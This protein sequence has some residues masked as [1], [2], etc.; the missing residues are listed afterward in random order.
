M[1]NR[2]TESSSELLMCI[3]SLSPK[4]SFSNFDVKRLLRLAKLYPDDFSSR[5]RFELN[6]QLRVF[7]TFVKSSPQFSGLQCIGDLAKTL[8]KTE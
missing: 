5:N 8:V 3:A 2:F 4:D 1:S 7:I 6:E